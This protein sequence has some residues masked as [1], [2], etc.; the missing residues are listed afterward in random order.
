MVPQ[1]HQLAAQNRWIQTRRKHKTAPT[2]THGDSRDDAASVPHR[3]CC[4]GRR[5][6][7]I[8]RSDIASSKTLRFD[9]HVRMR[10]VLHI[11]TEKTGS[12]SIQ[13]WLANNRRELKTQGVWHSQCLGD[14]MSRKIAV[15]GREPNQPDDGFKRYGISD[16]A[17]HGKWA[18]QL[19]KE[20]A[21]ELQLAASS[22]GQTYVISSEHCHSR[23]TST[24]MAARVV[25][26]LGRLSEDLEIV[27]FL[28]PQV[29]VLLSRLSTATRAGI[30]VSKRSLDISPD[31]PYYDYLALTRRWAETSGRRVSLMAFR[32]HSDVVAAFASRLGVSTAELQPPERVNESLD[33]RT[34]ALAN[35]VRL[36]RWVGSEKN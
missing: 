12:S 7:S 27:C 21:D 26:L 32:R 8:H 31:N 19:E 35:S 13:R 5:P 10:I 23:L 20:L 33:Y 6:G 34:I 25:S 22:G 3:V 36:P 16:A 2:R 29:D 28:R 15:Y 9:A 11:G 17:A 24:E 30:K 18:S 14:P 4:F 1:S